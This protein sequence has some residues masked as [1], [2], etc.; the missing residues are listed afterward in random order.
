MG[1]VEKRE[2]RISETELKFGH[3]EYVHTDKE[4][5]AEEKYVANSH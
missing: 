1:D 2:L 3:L 4:V 5:Q